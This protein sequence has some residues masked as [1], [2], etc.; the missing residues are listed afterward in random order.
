MDVAHCCIISLCYW[1]SRWFTW[2]WWTTGHSGHGYGDGGLMALVGLLGP[3]AL[4]GRMIQVGLVAL[5]VLPPT[6][7]EGKF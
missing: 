4:E 3:V 6:N 1:G 7:L 2:S 5:V